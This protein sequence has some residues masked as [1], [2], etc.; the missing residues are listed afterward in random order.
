MI[1]SKAQGNISLSVGK[2]ATWF[3]IIKTSSIFKGRRYF[4]KRS[5]SSLNG[6]VSVCYWISI[7]LLTQQITLFLEGGPKL[8]KKKT[9]IISRSENKALYEQNSQFDDHVKF[10]FIFIFTSPCT[11]QKRT[12]R[13][14]WVN[15]ILKYDI[16]TW[17]CVRGELKNRCGNPNSQIFHPSRKDD[18]PVIARE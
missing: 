3:K 4:Y 17:T 15:M 14:L 16:C 6:A 13:K 2:K 12:Q 8:K 1:K 9:Y 11:H 5:F 10:N 18:V 7:F